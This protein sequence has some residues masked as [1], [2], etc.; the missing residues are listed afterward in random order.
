[1]R[2]A[3]FAHDKPRSVRGGEGSRDQNK[4]ANFD[5]AFRVAV[6]KICR[7]MSNDIPERELSAFIFTS[8]PKRLPISREN[9]G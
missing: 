1:M 4:N 5:S 9:A 8:P 6:Q 3:L 2:A 7:A